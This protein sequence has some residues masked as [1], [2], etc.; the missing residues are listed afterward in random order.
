M[1]DADQQGD[2]GACKPTN[3]NKNDVKEWTRERKALIF[4]LHKRQQPSKHKANTDHKHHKPITYIRVET[5]PHFQILFWSDGGVVGYWEGWGGEN[6]HGI[7]GGGG[8][9]VLNHAGRI[10]SMFQCFILI[11]FN[12]LMLC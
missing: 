8:G 3:N 7:G 2:R 10:V 4:G 5:C 12:L 1:F 9:S 6:K 11:C